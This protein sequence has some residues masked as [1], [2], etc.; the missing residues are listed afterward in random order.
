MRSI[1]EPFC[2]VVEARD[3]HEAL[4]KVAE[5]NPDLII[6]D[7]MLP[8]VHPTDPAELMADERLCPAQC[9]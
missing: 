6:A 9:A 3:G 5:C 8:K 4:E 7:I 2:K 1:F